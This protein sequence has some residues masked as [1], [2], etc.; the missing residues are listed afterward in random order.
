VR[1]L[2]LAK[3]ERERNVVANDVRAPLGISRRRRP[4]EGEGPP[5]SA[6]LSFIV[7]RLPLLDER[8]CRGS[9]MTG[10]N[11]RNSSDLV[12]SKHTTKSGDIS[13]RSFM[14]GGALVGGSAYAEGLPGVATAAARDQGRTIDATALRNKIKGSVATPDNAGCCSM[15]CGTDCTR[16]IDCR[17]RS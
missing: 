14:I 13:R 1:A 10:S 9:V 2:A 11:A 4:A 12:C 16:P 5:T 3:E 8:R 17:K 7:E 15:A 6:L